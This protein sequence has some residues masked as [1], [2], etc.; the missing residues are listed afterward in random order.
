MSRV[1]VL[2]VGETWITQSIHIKGVDSFTTSSLESGADAFIDALTADG[3]AEVDHLM[4]HDVAKKFPDSLSVLSGYDAIIISDIGRRSFELHPDT[5]YSGIPK[6]DRLALLHDWVKDGGGLG[7]VGGYLSFQGLNGAARYRGSA[8]ADVLPVIMQEWDDCVEVPVG[9]VP[10]V[11]RDHEITC[12]IPPDWRPLLGY[13]KLR[14]RPG[15]DVLCTV[16][17]HPLLAVGTAG[18]GRSLA[19]ASDMGPHWC[20]EAFSNWEGF[21]EL[22]RGAIRWLSGS[23]QPGTPAA[24]T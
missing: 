5:W 6:V 7:M 16:D 24:W 19:W 13:N 2:L 9:T 20:P 21:R 22:W 3:F 18:C 15:C 10:K 14:A 1:K 11:V 23:G 4:G 17:D 8:I 12:R